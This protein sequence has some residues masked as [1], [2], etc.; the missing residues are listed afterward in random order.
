[1]LYKYRGVTSATQPRQLIDSYELLNDIEVIIG[2]RDN[3]LQH[4]RPRMEGENKIEGVAGPLPAENRSRRQFLVLAMKGVLM[5]RREPTT[6]NE[7]STFDEEPT[8][9]KDKTYIKDMAYNKNT[10]CIEERTYNNEN[11]Y[12]EEKTCN[13]ELVGLR[14][15]GIIYN[16]LF[17]ERHGTKLFAVRTV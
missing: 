3:G 12:L 16:E 11:G 4:N 15:G 2:H 9:G 10:T 8:Q 1:L 7:K 13:G 14:N 6:H 17:S 5:M